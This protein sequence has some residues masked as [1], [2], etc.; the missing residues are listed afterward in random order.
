MESRKQYLGVL[1]EMYLR[2]K[3]KKEKSQI[4]D[5]SFYEGPVRRGN[6]SSERYSPG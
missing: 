3:A 6:M 1:S 2:A 5:E 4:L